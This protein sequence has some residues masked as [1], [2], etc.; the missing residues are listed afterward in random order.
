MSRSPLLRDMQ[1]QVYG[2]CCQLQY[3]SWI[4]GRQDHG[5][6]PEFSLKCNFFL[7][8]FTKRWKNVGKFKALQ[9]AIISGNGHIYRILD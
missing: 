8:I 6:Y 2:S 4:S 9:S 7:S 1:N 3:L 5:C